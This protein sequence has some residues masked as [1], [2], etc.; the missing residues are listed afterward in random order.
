MNVK[1]IQG[2]YEW[3]FLTSPYTNSCASDWGI[4]EEMRQSPKELHDS[5]GGKSHICHQDYFFQ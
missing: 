5:G 1:F 4:E 3:R 2:K